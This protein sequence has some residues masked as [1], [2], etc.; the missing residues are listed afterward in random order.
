M[1][2]YF[3][4]SSYDYLPKKIVFCNMQDNPYSDEQV[5]R[6]I[7][8]VS[9]STGTDSEIFQGNL[10][11]FNV[12]ESEMNELV[13]CIKRLYVTENSESGMLSVWKV[14]GKATDISGATIPMA[15]FVERVGTL[16]KSPIHK[17]IT[18]E[19]MVNILNRYVTEYGDWELSRVSKVCGKDWFFEFTKGSESMTVPLFS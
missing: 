1:E 2:Y 6:A 9:G 16:K 3:K 10:T 15:Y 12:N 18:L 7:T 11:Q 4:F 5:I 19:E 13:S 14:C 8:S 17:P